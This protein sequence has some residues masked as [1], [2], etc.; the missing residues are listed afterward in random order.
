MT[1]L[2]SRAMKDLLWEYYFY[3]EVSGNLDDARDM[4]AELKKVCAKLRILGSYKKIT[5]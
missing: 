3:A 1:C 4:L 2:R 5:I